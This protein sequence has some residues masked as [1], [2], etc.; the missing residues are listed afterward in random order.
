M[1]VN[2][3]SLVIQNRIPKNI[4]L[5]YETIFFGEFIL[6]MKSFTII[7]PGPQCHKKNKIDIEEKTRR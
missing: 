2:E 4:H 7:T 3:I 6:L 1:I 5:S